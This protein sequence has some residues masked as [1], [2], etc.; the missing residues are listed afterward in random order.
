MEQLVLPATNMDNMDLSK[1]LE[2][3]ER[4]M[5]DLPNIGVEG[6]EVQHIIIVVVGLVTVV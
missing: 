1:I 6:V 2:V 4:G 3:R 5:V